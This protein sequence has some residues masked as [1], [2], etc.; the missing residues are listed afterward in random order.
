M[1]L[2]GIAKNVRELLL[3]RMKRWKLSLTTNRNELGEVK[4]NRGT[5]QGDSL[6]PLLFVLCMISMSLVL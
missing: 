3:K 4:F 2:T 1:E 6:S 5:F